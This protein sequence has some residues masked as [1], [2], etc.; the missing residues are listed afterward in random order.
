[1]PDPIRVDEAVAHLPS[2]PY[3]FHQ[4]AIFQGPTELRFR[5]DLDAP[6]SILQLI[7]FR[8]WI[9]DTADLKGILDGEPVLTRARMLFS[10]ELMPM[11]F[12]F[13]WYDGPSHNLA[14]WEV[15]GNNPFISHLSTYVDDIFEATREMASIFGAPFHRF[16]T[17]SHT[18]P[19]V[20]GKKRFI[21]SIF[22]TRLSLGFDLKLIQKVPWDYNDNDWLSWKL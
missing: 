14:N 22:N 3:Q 6:R 21:E 12:E 18:N 8:G 5:P 19:A 1:M 9:E 11:E 7:G 15:N 4:V 10:Y 20:I 17:Q 16:I 13:L 2:L